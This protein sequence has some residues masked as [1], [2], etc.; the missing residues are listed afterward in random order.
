MY[1]VIIEKLLKFLLLK[2][3]A[4]WNKF[5]I[6]RTNG[7]GCN[8]LLCREPLKCY[9]RCSSVCCLWPAIFIGHL[10]ALYSSSVCAQSWHREKNKNSYSSV[11]APLPV[12]INILLSPRLKIPSD[13]QNKF[14]CNI[15]GHRP[16]NK[17]R[18]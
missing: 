5:K 7:A 4:V 11:S 6:K 17:R 9:L 2:C 18:A 15:Q 8:V 10:L 13:E 3:C 16:H 1:N 14:L 12:T